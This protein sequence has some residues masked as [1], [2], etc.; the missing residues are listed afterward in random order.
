LNCSAPGIPDFGLISD[1]HHMEILFNMYLDYKNYRGYF[2]K[3]GFFGKI[4]Y[5]E[6]KLCGPVFN[7][8]Y[9]FIW[10]ETRQFLLF[11]QL[12]P[13]RSIYWAVGNGG[14]GRH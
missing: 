4:Y 14:H 11:L 5:L 1:E 6:I 13:S 7:P 3:F 8:N 10:A 2:Q 9:S 12:K